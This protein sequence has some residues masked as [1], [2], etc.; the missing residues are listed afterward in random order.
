MLALMPLLVS[1][2]CVRT[3]RDML[4]AGLL[5]VAVHALC[6]HA[7]GGAAREVTACVLIALVANDA[8]VQRRAVACGVPKLLREIL[9]TAHGGPTP[10][11]E[12][13]RFESLNAV[14]AACAE[15]HGEACAEPGCELCGMQP[16]RCGAAGC[17]LRAGAGAGITLKRCASC[18]TAAY[19]CMAHQRDAWAAH[20]LVCGAR[21][22]VLAAHAALTNETT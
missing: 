7:R 2:A 6:Q 4:D 3:K 9:R 21:A 19:C 22:A 13:E 14:L 17:S 8:L 10:G 18:R 1:E 12:R 11:E 5:M 15:A 20:K 16:G